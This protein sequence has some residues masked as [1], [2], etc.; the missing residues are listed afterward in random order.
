MIYIFTILTFFSILGAVD[1]C[2]NLK[3]GYGEKFQEGINVTG[4][5]VLAMVGILSLSPILSRGIEPFVQVL[6]TVT[7][8]DPSIYVNSFLALD[9]GGYFLAKDLAIN[10]ELVNFS[11]LILGSMLGTVVIFTMPVAF[12]I[13][14]EESKD[15]F[16]KGILSGIATIPL[17]CLVSGL[18]MGLK[19]PLVLYN[20]IPVVF[21]AISISLGLW[22]FPIK[23]CKVFNN[24][25][26]FM[27]ILIS[28]GLILTILEVMLNIQL[29]EGLNSIENSMSVII[30]IALTLAGAFPFL[31]FVNRY[32]SR[33]LSKFGKIL[34]MDDAGVSGFMASLVNSIPMF[35]IF[36]KMNDD[37]KII[38]SA[39]SV[40]GAYIFGGQLGFVGGISPETVVPF[41]VGKLVAG[42]SAIYLAKIIFIR[43]KGASNE[44]ER[45]Y[46]KIIF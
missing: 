3:L 24:F 19:L 1:R 42:F 8:V 31:H 2:L 20:L 7:G 46:G 13:I 29:I 4:P 30:R 33:T 35:G 15:A 21:I 28:F 16:S 25:G 34:G 39:F 17:G 38:N 41:I 14:K 27:T 18:L 32:F 26:K 44:E 23:T 11:G 12:G 6:Y 45:K 37:S 36:D 10:K 22:F 9:M 43:K 5:L 40:G